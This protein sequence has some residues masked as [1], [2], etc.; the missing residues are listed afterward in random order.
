MSPSDPCHLGV[1]AV[2]VKKQKHRHVPDG[3]FLQ[4]S[5]AF[6]ACTEQRAAGSLCRA[7][8]CWLVLAN[9]LSFVW[10]FTGFLARVIS[11]WW[12]SELAVLAAAQGDAQDL[13]L[14]GS[15]GK[16]VLPL[17]THST[18]CSATTPCAPEPFPHVA[19]VGREA[20][21]KNGNQRCS[22]LSFACVVVEKGR[23]KYFLVSNVANS[24][25]W[26]EAVQALCCPRGAVLP[27]APSHPALAL[28]ILSLH[29][30]TLKM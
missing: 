25:F 27:G 5:Q 2:E 1:I 19:W 24:P 17:L 23:T 8:L 26:K 13:L 30:G 16:G 7:P 28:L 15:Q 29:G 14:R 6:A 22:A 11:A 21:E 9:Q 18:S 12:L 20:C 4:S 3:K 10:D